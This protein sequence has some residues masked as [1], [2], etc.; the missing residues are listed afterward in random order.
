MATLSL[1]TQSLIVLL[2][3]VAVGLLSAQLGCKFIASY[4]QSISMPNPVIKQGLA[5]KIAIIAAGC[6]FAAWTF[7][8]Y[9]AIFATIFFAIALFSS[10]T[11]I[12]VSRVPKIFTLAGFVVLLINTAVYSILSLSW[13]Y[14]FNLVI[15]FF[16]MAIMAVVFKDT[17][18]GRADVKLMAIYIGWIATF[19]L[20]TA[21]I[22]YIVC[23]IVIFTSGI[24]IYKGR[25][26]YPIAPYICATSI[27]AWLVYI[28][29]Y[30][31][32][33]ELLKLWY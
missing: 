27:I 33:N 21:L 8:D 25:K 3:I 2:C 5:V 14:A 7:S 17:D 4:F 15:V 19:S 18:L 13:Y 6:I 23:L 10:I 22:T 30:N 29:P 28:A 31:T 26:S 24:S 9:S 12:T 20:S 1:F 11:D 32:V 16:I